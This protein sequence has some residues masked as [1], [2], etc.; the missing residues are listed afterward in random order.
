[1]SKRKLLK[2]PAGL[3]WNVAAVTYAFG[4][5][6]LGL[7]LMTR[8]GGWT[9]PACG[10]VLLAH[11]LVIGS[12]LIH[13][14]AHGSILTDVR[15]NA[16]FGNALLWLNGACYARYEDVVHKHFR[17][18][19]DR[20]DVV[21]FDFRPHLRRHPWA[22]GLVQ[23]LEW[24]CVPAVDLLMHALMIVLPFT[25]DER[26]HLR[27]RVLAMLAIRTAAFVALAWISWRAVLL[28]ALAYLLFLHALRFMDV[29]QHTYDV[30]ETLGRERGEEARRHDRAYEYR[31]TYSNLLSRR[32]PWLNLL[33]LNFGY[34]NAHHVKPAVAWY[35]L[36]RLHRELYG[37]ATDRLLPL[38]ALLQSYLRHRVR[39]VLNDD[40][41]ERAVGDARG[42]VGVVGVS[43]LTAH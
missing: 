14:F 15:W 26:R 38:G 31:N 43:F 9:V 34:H 33:V 42:F 7:W 2:D 25:L 18:H 12:Y 10:A 39:R 32:W 17:H 24:A 21:L 6:A 29:H 3:G 4:G 35:A 13:E 36:P 27:G 16:R 30:L 19:A 37:E 11:A 28:Y 1:M 22:L 23:G 5:Y 8:P 41:P 20:A 40:P